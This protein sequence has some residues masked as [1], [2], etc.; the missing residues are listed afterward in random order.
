MAQSYVNKSLSLS[1]T[2]EFYI[3][4]FANYLGFIDSGGKSFTYRR[5]YITYESR[6][7]TP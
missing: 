2:Y 5:G 4:R 7:S 1:P 3:E 6:I